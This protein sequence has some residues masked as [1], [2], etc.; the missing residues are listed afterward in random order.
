MFWQEPRSYIGRTEDTRAPANESLQLHQGY[1]AAH[2]S[3]SVVRVMVGH[4][5]QRAI[6]Q[7]A[8]NGSR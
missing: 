7:D 1:T 3:G 5:S 2:E 8:R 6:F 4:R